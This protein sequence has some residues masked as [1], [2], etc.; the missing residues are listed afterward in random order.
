MLRYD[1]PRALP[2]H[3]HDVADAVVTG[4]PLL[5]LP[6]PCARPPSALLAAAGSWEAPARPSVVGEPTRDDFP[7]HQL[8]HRYNQQE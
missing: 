2:E 8:T 3:V 6:R 5:I 4:S 1:G 7:D